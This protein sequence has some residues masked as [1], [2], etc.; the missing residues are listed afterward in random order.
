MKY[1]VGNYF[2]DTKEF[3]KFRYFINLYDDYVK[4][5]NKKSYPI[6]SSDEFIDSIKEYG[7]VG[8]VIKGELV[9]VYLAEYN[10]CID[11]NVNQPNHYQIGN[12]G[13]ECKDFISAWVG[14][15]YYSVFCFCNIMKYLVRAEKKN[16]LEDYK[17]ALKYLDMIIEAG[18]DIIVLDIADIGIEDGTKE[19]TGVEWNEIILEITKGLSA[20][21]AL[22]LD[23]VFR[24]LADE[25]YHLCRIRLADFIDMYKDTM[26][27]RPPV[28]AK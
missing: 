21:Q 20:R 27:C 14:K 19:Y 9:L 1:S 5:C 24:A 7:V 6:V 16:K 28:P 12:T 4:Y 17:K 13:L 18:A 8:E 23:G 15:G 2:A 3:G 11:K 10:R 26:V 25:N 22:L